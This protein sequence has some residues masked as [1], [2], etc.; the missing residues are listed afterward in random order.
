[1]VVVMMVVEQYHSVTI[2]DSSVYYTLLVTSLRGSG[3][4]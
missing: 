2:E 4:N 1:M 3:T